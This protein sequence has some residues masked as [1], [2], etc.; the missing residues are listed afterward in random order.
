VIE[1]KAV[2]L[3]PEN[4]AVWQKVLHCASKK[5]YVGLSIYC[6]YFDL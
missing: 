4:F 5:K 1:T 2:N 6:F 3:A